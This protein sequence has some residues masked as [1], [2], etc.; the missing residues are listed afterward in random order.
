MDYKATEYINDVLL[1][2]ITVCRLV[3]L[4]VDRH[5]RDLARVGDPDFPFYFDE[6]AAKFAIDFFGFLKHSKGE[7]AGKPIILEPWQQFSIWCVYGWLR[8]ED[9][10]RR[11]RT[12]YEEIARKNGKS[13][14]LSGIGLFGLIADGEPGAE[15]YT[16]A[17]DKDQAKIIWSEAKRMVEQSSDI[18][19]IVDVFASSLAVD[20]THSKFMPLSSETRNKDGLNVHVGEIDEYHEHQTDELYN[21]LKSGMASRRQPI[22]WIITTAGFN[23]SSPCKREHDYAVMVLEGIVPND[24]YFAIIYTLDEEDNPFDEKNWIKSNPNLGVS[25]KLDLLREQ[26]NTATTQPSKI[27]EFKT[28]RL[29]I[30]TSA[31]T[32]WILPTKWNKCKSRFDKKALVGR[33]CVLAI[34]LSSTIDISGF[35]E[36]FPPVE[37]NEK[38]KLVWKFFIPREGLEDRI[39]AEG[40]PYDNWIKDGFVIATQGD[41]IDYNR[42]EQEIK[43]DAEIF[44]INEVPHD[45]YNA[46]QLVNNL[47]DAGF[48]CIKF[49]QNITSISPAA[50]MFEKMVLAAEIEVED[51]PV[52]DYMMGCAE[53]YSDA[54]GNIKVI[55]PDRRKSAKRIDGVIMAIMALY[56]SIIGQGEQGSPYESRGVVV[57]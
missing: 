39:K 50:K 18:K 48:N 38:P 25:V 4:A 15:I 27:N 51:N 32:R 22:L 54:N 11:F 35:C 7:W 41:V 37:P 47:T 53:V 19:K 1:G 13:T 20:K 28:K 45:P 40:V 31:Y 46:T 56:R 43:N 29:N 16:A 6:E 14:K 5:V 36:V 3:R 57:V 34:D 44:D 24:A 42:I 52:M 33:S 8:K 26:A 10:L 2:K 55:K 49:P 30:W 17:N 21:V 9:H 12:I 23:S